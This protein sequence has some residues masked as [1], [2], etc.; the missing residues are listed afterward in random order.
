M[1]ASPEISVASVIQPRLAKEGEAEVKKE[2][3]AAEGAVKPAASTTA[4]AAP[5]V[6]P[7][8]KGKEK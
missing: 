4:S 2:G 8:K 6:K 1:L 3:E 7:E 5:A